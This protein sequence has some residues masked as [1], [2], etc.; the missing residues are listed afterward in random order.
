MRCQEGS[1]CRQNIVFTNAVDPN[2][3]YVGYNYNPVV[4]MTDNINKIKETDSTNTMDN[5]NNNTYYN[6]KK[7]FV[8]EKRRKQYQQ[9]QQQDV[10]NAYINH[11]VGINL[12]H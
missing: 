2:K 9:Q 7:K 3:S 4:Q 8:F 12:N 1:R 5:T 6:N 10:M 11:K